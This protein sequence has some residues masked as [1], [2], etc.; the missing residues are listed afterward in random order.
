MPVVKPKVNLTNNIS[1][2]KTNKLPKPGIIDDT[3]KTCVPTIPTECNTKPQKPHMREFKTPEELQISTIYNNDNKLNDIVNY[4]SGMKWSVTYFSQVLNIG[5]TTRTPDKNIPVTSQQYRRINNFQLV[6]SSG[7]DQSSPENITGNAVVNMGISPLKDDVFMAMLTGGRKAIFIVTMV[8]MKK[9]NLHKVFDIEF[10]LFKFLDDDVDLYNMLIKKT[11]KELE[12]NRNHISEHTTPILEVKDMEDRRMLNS[13]LSEMTKHYLNNFVHPK[14]NV[15]AIPVTSK[16]TYTDT[17]LNDFILDIV[18][19]ENLPEFLRLNRF[20]LKDNKINY[21]IWDVLTQRDISLLKRCDKYMKYEYRHV[22]MS[23]DAD[24]LLC[25]V[26]NLYRVVKANEDTV[27]LPENVIDISQF[28]ETYGKSRNAKYEM[29][30]LQPSI[31][32]KPEEPETPTIP[33]DNNEPVTLPSFPD[34]DN[35][36]VTLPSFPDKDLELLPILEKP[37]MKQVNDQFLGSMFS[38]GKHKTSK[39]KTVKIEEEVKPEEEDEVLKKVKFIDS[40]GK[41]YLFPIIDKDNCYVFNKTLYQLQYGKLSPIEE[42]VVQY[43]KKEVI[44]KDKLFTFVEQ[45]YNWSTIEQYYLIPV[46]MLLI[47]DYLYNTFKD[48]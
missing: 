14:S 41:E 20:D 19:T 13:K 8:E 31:P 3:G 24:R 6:L 40:D 1:I 27:N 48:L 39:P 43:L 12:F 25:Y 42:L 11:V 18:E 2:P 45:Y 38:I 47:K 22:D 4:I 10:K 35:I 9:Y 28:E 15:I 33:D 30:D 36:P 34:E 17:M 37:E 5:E 46:L 23:N 7:L 29:V 16:S 32:V 26:G 21:T 44:N